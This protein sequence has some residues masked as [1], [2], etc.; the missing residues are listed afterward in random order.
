MA[1][2]DH[3]LSLPLLEV[4]VW[5]L[6]WTSRRVE[7]HCGSVCSR[8]SFVLMAACWLRNYLLRKVARPRVIM[9]HIEAPRLPLMYHLARLLHARTNMLPLTTIHVPLVLAA[10]I[11]VWRSWPS[12]WKTLAPGSDVSAPIRR[13]HFE[14]DYKDHN[15]LNCG[16]ELQQS[17]WL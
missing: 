1:T 7:L 8:M 5:R 10:I 16:P 15:S 3:V 9:R 11:T 17:W 14:N 2:T 4:I 6:R 12:L 13:L